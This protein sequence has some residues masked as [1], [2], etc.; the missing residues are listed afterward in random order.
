MLG[1]FLLTVFV[2]VFT[3]GS[4]LLLSIVSFSTGLLIIS[5]AHTKKGR[6][7]MSTLQRHVPIR[8]V[9]STTMALPLLHIGLRKCA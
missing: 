7:A 1:R 8:A 2:L 9:R 6:S 5:T 4:P 3:A